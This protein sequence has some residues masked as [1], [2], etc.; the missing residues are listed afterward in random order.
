MS[1]PDIMTAFLILGMSKEF[2]AI[3]TKES[4]ITTNSARW[5]YIS[6]DEHEQLTLIG[7]L[8]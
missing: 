3:T 7:K 4:P 1:P 2:P 5:Y 6:A 8:S